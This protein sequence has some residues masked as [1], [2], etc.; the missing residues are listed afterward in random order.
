M[1]SISAFCNTKILSLWERLCQNVK[2][3]I[4]KVC[5]LLVRLIWRSRLNRASCGRKI[6]VINVSRA[7]AISYSNRKLRA[8]NTYVLR[9][10]ET[11][12]P[13]Q[14]KVRAAVNSNSLSDELQLISSMCSEIVHLLLNEIEQFPT[15]PINATRTSYL[16][17]RLD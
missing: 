12:L 7:L 5:L 9:M 16:Y 6:N 13:P 4:F 14:F 3:Q 15:R 11:I 17:G 8:H 10:R 1:A 2:Q